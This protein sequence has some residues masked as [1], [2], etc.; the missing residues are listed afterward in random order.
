MDEVQV[1]IDDYGAYEYLPGDRLVIQDGAA[2][3]MRGKP[4]E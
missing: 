2:T 3:L 4:R 1:V